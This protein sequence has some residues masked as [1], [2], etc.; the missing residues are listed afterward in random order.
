MPPARTPA[1]AA[2][3]QELVSRSLAARRTA[4]VAK[5]A[6]QR[7]G[8]PPAEI[9]QA[10]SG[11]RRKSKTASKAQTRGSQ[12]FASTKSAKAERTPPRKSEPVASCSLPKARPNRMREWPCPQKKLWERKKF[13][14]AP[15]ERITFGTAKW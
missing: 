11:E 15:S 2:N 7:S 6:I 9:C 10:T 4:A 1:R 12:F 5:K 8:A 14:A 3:F 13:G